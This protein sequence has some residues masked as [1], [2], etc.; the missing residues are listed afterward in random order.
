MMGPMATVQK[1]RPVHPDATVLLM[2]SL[3]LF[4][5]SASYWHPPEKSFQLE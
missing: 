4:Q 1:Q 3:V 2:S 5:A